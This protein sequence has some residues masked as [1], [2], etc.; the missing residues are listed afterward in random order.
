MHL[1]ES[2]FLVQQQNNT[3]TLLAQEIVVSYR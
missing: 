1:S 3:V 2:V